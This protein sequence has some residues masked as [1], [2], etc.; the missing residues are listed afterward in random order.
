[1]FFKVINDFE[2]HSN[3]QKNELKKSIQ[4]LDEKFNNLS[5]NIQP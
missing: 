5:R 2:D 4:I 1:L 3:K